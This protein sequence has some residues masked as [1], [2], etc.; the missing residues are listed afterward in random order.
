M[1][2]LCFVLFNFSDLFGKAMA[3]AW[4]WPGPSK[5]GQAVLLI[6]SLARLFLI[7]LLMF[8][9]VSPNNRNTEVRLANCDFFFIYLRR[10][11]NWY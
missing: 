9:N 1:P 7:P 11:R 10:G 3:Q 8:C 6:V 5:W 2:V 4:K